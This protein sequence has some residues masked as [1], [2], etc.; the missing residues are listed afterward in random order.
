MV[1]SPF[2]LAATGLR[3]MTHMES[4]VFCMTATVADAELTVFCMTATVADASFT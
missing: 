1:P 4:T 2:C 3:C